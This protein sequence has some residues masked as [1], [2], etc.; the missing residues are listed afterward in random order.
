MTDNLAVQV[1]V[2]VV[3]DPEQR[4]VWVWNEKWGVFGLPM[5]KVR[6]RANSREPAERA[7]FHAGAEAL[8]VPVRVLPGTLRLPLRRKG[9]SER[10]GMVRR[11]AYQIYGVEPHPDFA[12]RVAPPGPH[13]WLTAA[14]ALE[15]GYEPLSPTS[16]DILDRVLLLYPPGRAPL[17][18]SRA[19]LAIVWRPGPGGRPLWLAQWNSGWKCF[20]LVGGHKHR[21]ETF[22]QCLLREVTAELHLQEGTDFSADEKPLTR[23]EYTAYSE[24]YK[25]ETMYEITAVPLEVE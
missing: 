10:Q 8:G 17:R 6:P 21:N 24:R 23:Q 4:H 18:R 16:R 25:A 5:S 15:A 9:F 7:A 13:L 14:Q 22:R 20:H 3:T 2:A 12:A 1:A 19:A 11:Y